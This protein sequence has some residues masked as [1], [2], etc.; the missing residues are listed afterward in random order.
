MNLQWMFNVQSAFT[1]D[2]KAFLYHINN[3]NSLLFLLS[4]R[5]QFTDNK[6]SFCRLHLD[7]HSV[8]CNKMCQ[9]TKK[10]AINWRRL[11]N[12]SMFSISIAMIC[13]GFATFKTFFDIDDD[14]CERWIVWYKNVSY[15][16]FAATIIRANSWAVQYQHNAIIQKVSS[17]F[18]NVRDILARKY[19]IGI[20]SNGIET[21]F[22]LNLD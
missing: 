19:S 8:H 22:Y 2:W 9:W 12:F 10:T 14:V 11:N 6:I 1:G 13:F 5:I 20:T 21:N 4:N 7:S 15:L 18:F 3:S 17:P 16:T